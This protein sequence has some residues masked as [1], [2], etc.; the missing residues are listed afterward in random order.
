[1]IKEQILD[2]YW[3]AI[4]ALIRFA[5]RKGWIMAEEG[6]KITWKSVY[7]WWKNARK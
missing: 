6:Q 4:R 5:H 7:R 3:G 1:M 2:V